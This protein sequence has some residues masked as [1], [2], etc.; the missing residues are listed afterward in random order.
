MLKNQ[1]HSPARRRKVGITL[2]IGVLV[3]TGIAV[4]AP[5]VA[6]MTAQSSVV[7]AK[8]S[9][10]EAAA[11]SEAVVAGR[12]ALTDAASAVSAAESSGL[13]LGE[14]STAV[15][16]SGL[17][18][19]MAD[20][21]DVDSLTSLELPIVRV[22]AGAEIASVTTQTAALRERQAAAAAAAEA[23]QQAAAAEAAA[24]ALANANTPDGA[25]ATAAA[26]AADQYGWGSGEFECL[27][28]LWEK[29][30]GWNYEAYNEDGG[31]TGIPQSLPGDKMASFGADWAT[32][33]TTQIRW[34]LDYIQ[35][36]YG[37]PC[38]AWGHSQAMNWY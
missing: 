37:S 26:I 16:T 8:A 28:S 31:A 4:A 38:S 14:A 18:E 25:K 27:N 34:G 30:S 11:A 36:A 3:A 19:A 15:D 5:A 2:A 32:N 33:A 9:A 20:L 17:L 7:D 12:T 35:R 21:D 23:A 13:D 1:L 10:I 6:A 22:K 29:E 24:A